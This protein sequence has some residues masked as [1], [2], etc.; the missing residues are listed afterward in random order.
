MS[1]PLC[2]V[3]LILLAAAPVAV[4]FAR[5]DRA[6][7]PTTSADDL[8]DAVDAFSLRHRTIQGCGYLVTNY[9]E[10]WRARVARSDVTPPGFHFDPSDFLLFAFAVDRGEAKWDVTARAFQTSGFGPLIPTSLS[11]GKS[12][13]ADDPRADSPWAHCYCDGEKA[14]DQRSE[15]MATWVSRANAKGVP[16]GGTDIILENLGVLAVP[17]TIDW[18]RKAAVMGEETVAG[19]PTRRLQLSR[20]GSTER[21]ILRTRASIW[22]AD[23]GCPMRTTTMMW[24][25]DGDVDVATRIVRERAADGLATVSD[26]YHY[27]Y[28]DDPRQPTA[29]A[30]SMR[31]GFADLACDERINWEQRFLLPCIG[32][33]FYD[34]IWRE[35]PWDMNSLDD[36]L[37]RYHAGLISPPG[38]DLELF[39]ART[40]REF[41]S[42]L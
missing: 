35:M 25:R 39:P 9:A 20:E 15:E 38:P 32:A 33:Q 1:K 28:S 5:T 12:P 36:M 21:A 7:Q 24:L 30:W 34:K 2:R 6:A 19:E 8:A 18:V 22:V 27:S 41:E 37:D 14:V 42:R 3:L 13:G 16:G 10:W 31:F 17:G 23:D 26:V 40:K 29:W 11:Y 4:L